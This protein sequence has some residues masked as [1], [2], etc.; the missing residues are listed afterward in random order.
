MRSSSSKLCP[1]AV[2]ASP[3]GSLGHGDL[4]KTGGAVHIDRHSLSGSSAAGEGE[5]TADAAGTEM[6]SLDW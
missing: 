6:A 1:T 2:S 5:G 4:I 3:H